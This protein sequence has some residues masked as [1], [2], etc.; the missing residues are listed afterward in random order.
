[1]HAFSIWSIIWVML[2]F[3][4]S[5]IIPYALILRCMGRSKTPVAGVLLTGLDH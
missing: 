4:H 2:H 3:P 1:M 5:Q